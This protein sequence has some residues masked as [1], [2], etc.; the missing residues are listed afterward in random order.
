MI[1]YLVIEEDSISALVERVNRYSGLG[2]SL[3]GGISVSKSTAHDS[4]YHYVQAMCK[5]SLQKTN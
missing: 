5:V 2:Y 1:N 4:L 3:V